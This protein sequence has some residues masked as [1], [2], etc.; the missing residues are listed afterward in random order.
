M[1]WG[2]LMNRDITS[3]AMLEISAHRLLRFMPI[4][5]RALAPAQNTEIVICDVTLL[6]ESACLTALR[7]LSLALR[8][9]H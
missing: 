9:V 1:E 6:T 8:G 2:V 4:K 7:G 3:H 5:S